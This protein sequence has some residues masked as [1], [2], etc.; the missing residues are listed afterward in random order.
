MPSENSLT[1]SK[2]STSFASSKNARARVA[3]IVARLGPALVFAVWLFAGATTLGQAQPH[4]A[5]D[6][7]VT[8]LT[9]R[10]LLD[11]PPVA[12]VDSRRQ[13][14]A[15]E[16]ARM[17]DALF[18]LGALAQI[19]GV[20]FFWQS[21]W[22][23]RTRDTLRRATRT[24][25]LQRFGFGVVLAVVAGVA[26]LPFALVQYRELFA[27]GLSQEPIGAWMAGYFNLLA[28]EAVA[29]GLLVG[30]VL[31]LVDRLR[32]WYLAVAALVFAVVVALVFVEPLLIAP[33]YEQYAQ[34]EPSPLLTRLHALTEREGIGD[35]PI[36]YVVDSNWRVYEP[37]A[38]VDGIGASRRIVISESLL[39]SANDREIEFIVAHEIAQYITEDDL[40][41]ALVGSTLLVIA[42]AIAVLI[43]DRIGFRRDDDPLARFALVAALIGTSALVLSPLYTGYARS[44]EARADQTALAMTRDPA[45]GVRV[46]VRIAD[47]G[48]NALCEPWYQTVFTPE[49]SLGTRI[50]LVLG[51][52]DP[53]EP[54]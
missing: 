41:D 32:T 3:R 9:E 31:F 10:E 19:A 21:G 12:L 20:F 30:C 16:I 29:V 39:E 22:A 24:P 7:R 46:M 23:A 51:R 42:A 2:S 52:P 28:V 35:P 1:R 45:D 47:D 36:Y 37:T 6:Q 8:Q 25:F 50:A 4:P 13:T 53:C 49:P 48:M 38:H 17:H 15:H 40:K 11:T 14:A 5:L 18:T 44:L 27:V 33:L 43:S 26:N 34:L 54:F